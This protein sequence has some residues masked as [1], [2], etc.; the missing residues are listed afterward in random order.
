MYKPL[1]SP[2][3]LKGWVLRDWHVP[4]HPGLFWR[5]SRRVFLSGRFRVPHQSKVRRGPLRQFSRAGRRGVLRGVQG[6]VLLPPG[7]DAAQSSAVRRAAVLLPGGIWGADARARGVPLRRQPRP[8][9]DG[10][11][12][13]LCTR[14]LLRARCELRMP[15]GPVLTILTD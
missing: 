9:H 15:R 6:R 12:K 3:P 13:H 14:A 10:C 8:I 1:S 2:P 5:V 11:A 4:V 7:L